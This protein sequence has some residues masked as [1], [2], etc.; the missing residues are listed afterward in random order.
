MLQLITS[1]AHF[2]QNGCKLGV[3]AAKENEGK[4]LVHCMQ[5]V[6]RSVT[7]VIAYLMWSQNK[8]YGEVFE[9]VKE[10]RGIANP[11]IGFCLQVLLHTRMAHNLAVGFSVVKQ[12]HRTTFKSCLGKVPTN[13]G[14]IYQNCL[15]VWQNHI[16][17]AHTQD[18]VLSVK[19]HLKP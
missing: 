12:Q 11:N 3:Q 1:A 5:G 13:S 10:I 17:M 18:L 2:Y 4:V 19:Q 8:P 16:C 9:A 7:F 6:S 14:S 15:S